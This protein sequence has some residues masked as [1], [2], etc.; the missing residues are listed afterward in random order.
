MTKDGEPI[1][2][3]PLKS[4]IKTGLSWSPGFSEWQ[5]VVAAGLDL[6]RWEQID[7]YPKS[8]KLRVMAFNE[9]RHLVEAHTEAAKAEALEKDSKK[10]SGGGRR[11]RRARR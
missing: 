2:Q 4:G 9:L 8:F 10:K 5:A 1:D 6:Y 11:P 3:A 7:G